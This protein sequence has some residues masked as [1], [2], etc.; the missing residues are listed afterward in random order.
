MAIYNKG[1]LSRTE[2]TAVTDSLTGL[3]NR[4]AYKRAIAA[5]DSKMSDQFSCVYLDVNELHIINNKYGH[6]AGDEMLLFIAY[7]LRQ[8]FD[9]N[10]IYRMGGDEFLV[11]CE[12]MPREEVVL[13]LEALTEKVEAMNYHVSIGMDFRSKNIDT[14]AVV[15][16]AEKRMYEAKAEYYQQKELR[17]AAESNEER[18]VGRTYLGVYCVSFNN[19]TAYSILESRYF[20]KFADNRD[21]FS[22]A[23]LSY[24][25][26][27]VKPEHHRAMVGSLKYDV[28]RNILQEGRTPS[29]AYSK[30]NDERIVLTVYALPGQANINETIWLF[31]S[32]MEDGQP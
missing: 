3:S 13:R 6:A 31:E 23:L 27:T 20:K 29:I 32:V 16:E 4:L 8:T 26:E 19:D 30:L 9:G 21:S 28:L 12:G 22:E 10:P 14:E 18:S 11:F 25:H 5:F 1:Y 24:I 7:A 17:R 15:K 2:T